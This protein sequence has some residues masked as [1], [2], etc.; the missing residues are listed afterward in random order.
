MIGIVLVIFV[1]FAFYGRIKMGVRVILNLYYLFW[2]FYLHLSGNLSRAP[3][4]LKAGYYLNIAVPVI[5]TAASLLC[6]R[7]YESN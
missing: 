3:Y 2:V 4:E 5:Y 7:F 6:Y 1:S